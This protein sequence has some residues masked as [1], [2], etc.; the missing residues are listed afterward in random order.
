MIIA[1]EFDGTS[2]ITALDRETGKQLW[3][4]PRRDNITFSTPVVAHV[5]GKDQ[6]L[7][8][9]AEKVASYDPANGKLLWD[10]A[11]TTHATCGTM[12]WDGDIVF[13]SGGYPKAE[14]IAVKAD[15]SG[16]V[17]WKNNQKCYE[18]SMSRSTVTSTR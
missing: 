8:S 15:G 17:L 5:A 9:G 4:T 16:K 6:L 1:S 13:A 2:A 11:G 14:T 3:K 18:E 7:I 10:I 12:V